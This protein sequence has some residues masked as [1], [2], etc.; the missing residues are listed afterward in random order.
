MR[1]LPALTGVLILLAAAGC[2][3]TAAGTQRSGVRLEVVAAENFWG[4][5]AT[6]LAGSHGAVESVVDNPETDPHDYSPTAAD[7]RAMAS[8]D[9][10]IVNGIGY[11][12]WASRLIDA[13]PVASR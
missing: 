8:A 7:A 12:P 10:A 3:S 11:D 1:C 13:N 6:Q 2:G 9:V 4:S 5:I